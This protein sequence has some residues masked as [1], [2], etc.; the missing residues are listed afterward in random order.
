[1]NGER[2]TVNVK[3]LSGLLLLLP[4]ASPQSGV[5]RYTAMQLDCATYVEEVRTEIRSTAGTVVREERAGRDG[6]LMVRATETDAG[7]EVTAWYDSLTIWREGPEGR[8]TPDTEGLL[9]GR[10]RGAL[11]P[12]GRYTP[13]TS[14]FI[15][16]EVAEI[17]DL[18]GILDDFLPLLPA[19]AVAAGS[20]HQWT[21]HATSD[22]TTV[23][24]DSLAVPVRRDT[25]DSGS[26]E[27][28]PGL[29][30]VRWE[31]TLR[32][33]ARIPPGKPFVRGVVT[34][35][36]QRVRVERKATNCVNGQR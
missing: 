25:E 7:L 22:S 9:G 21:R 15:P 3:R 24:Q 10:W 2:S 6:V 27:W 4:Y 14:P 32:V 1:M 33:T 12:A 30:P 19:T 35:V 34:V 11:A 8:T 18:R 17:A 13:R 31:R 36:V 23:V 28:D 16:D 20:R 29:G 5:A 26:L